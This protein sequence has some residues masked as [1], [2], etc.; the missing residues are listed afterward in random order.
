MANKKAGNRAAASQAKAR[1]RARRRAKS[2]GP[3]LAPSAYAPPPASDEDEPV[4][5]EAQDAAPDEAQPADALPEPEPARQPVAAAAPMRREAAASAAAAQR[6][7]ART[8]AALAPEGGLRREVALI[9]ALTALI[10]A[11]LAFL[12]LGTTLGA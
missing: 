9:F 8:T 10:G 4:L 2:T 5:A 3:S 12:K 7:A 6:R 11:T 1:E